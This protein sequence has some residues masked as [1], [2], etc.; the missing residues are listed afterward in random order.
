MADTH[1]TLT[2]ELSSDLADRLRAVADAADT[3]PDRL[4]AVL[5]RD[6]VALQE[7]IETYANRESD[8][9]PFA[10]GAETVAS[11]PPPIGRL[12]GFEV[13]D[14]DAGRAEVTCSAGA[15]HANPMGTLHGGVLC[16][17]GDAAMGTA[18]ASTLDSGESFT[19]LELDAKY[20]RP[21]WETELTATA[22]VV[23]R[24]RT[25]GLVECDVTDGSGRLVARLNS[26]CLVLR[27]EAAEGR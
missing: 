20:L 7:S 27:G 4:L 21:V 11:T 1:E 18:F 19:T 25:T 24:G 12:L 5:A 23:E 16:D 13:T 9:S 14:L 15:R 10:G 8:E 17:V 6:R 2:V 3:D 22:E 26:V